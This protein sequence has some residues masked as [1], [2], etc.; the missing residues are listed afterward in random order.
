MQPP[1]ET[2]TLG[3]GLLRLPGCWC[4]RC[5]GGLAARFVS[6]YL[7]QLTAD[8]E[9]LEGPKGP[10]HDLPICTPGP[11]SICPAPAGSG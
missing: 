4:R 10:E 6:G 1:D 5:V 7:I 8:E 2:L 3:F 11:R 9:P